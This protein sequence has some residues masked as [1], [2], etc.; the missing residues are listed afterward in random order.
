MF[1][2][3]DACTSKLGDAERLPATASRSPSV[4]SRMPAF[5][6]PQPF[7]RHPAGRRGRIAIIRSAQMGASL[8]HGGVTSRQK[9]A[10]E[11]EEVAGIRPAAMRR[12]PDK[13]YLPQRR[14][15]SVGDA[16]KREFAGRKAWTVATLDRHQRRVARNASTGS[17]RRRLPYSAAGD[18]LVRDPQRSAASGVP[19]I[20]HLKAR[21]CLTRW[22]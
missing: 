20:L 18:S 3:C 9:L 19:E 17:P 2:R 10:A 22:I 11:L 5:A 1:E 6:T 21:S 8:G 13:E 12:K 4:S 15:R 16:L 14:T 7:M